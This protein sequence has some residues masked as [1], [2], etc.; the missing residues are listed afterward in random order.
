M[1]RRRLQLEQNLL[2]PTCQRAQSAAEDLR[3]EGLGSVCGE[4]KPY[5]KG[6]AKGGGQSRETEALGRGIPSR[7]GVLLCVKGA[8][9]TGAEPT[10]RLPA[11][12]SPLTNGPGQFY[13]K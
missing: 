13:P 12:L 3:P 6:N 2:E 8:R 10:Q 1:S 4:N 11:S 5:S 9:L 7:R